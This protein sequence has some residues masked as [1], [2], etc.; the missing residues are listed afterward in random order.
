MMYVLL[1]QYRYQ[2][3]TSY[4]ADIDSI[5]PCRKITGKGLSIMSDV[6]HNAVYKK[7]V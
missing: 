7:M 2:P 3:F 1:A 4:H 5:F 6:L